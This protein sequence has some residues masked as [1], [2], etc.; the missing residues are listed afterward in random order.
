[1]EDAVLISKCITTV[2]I[3]MLTFSIFSFIGS[4]VALGIVWRDHLDYINYIKGH[5][6]K[7]KG[8]K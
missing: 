3:W 8:K 1:M 7:L 4:C 5:K 2:E 6:N